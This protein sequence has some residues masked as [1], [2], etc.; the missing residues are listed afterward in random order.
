MSYDTVLLISHEMTY[1]GAPRSLLNIARV[2]ISK[3]RKINVWTLADGEFG[4]EF[5]KENISVEIIPDVI[6]KEE[7]EKYSLVILNTYFTAHL[8]KEIQK[9]TRAILYI[10]EAQNIPDLSRMCNLSPDDIKSANEAICVSDYA[11]DFIEGFCAPGRLTVINNFV[12]DKYRGRMN[13]IQNGVINFM[14]SGTYEKRKGYDIAIKAFLNMPEQLKKITRLHLVGQMPEWSQD[15]WEQ[16]RKEYDGRI[17][18]HGLISDEAERLKLYEEMNVFVVASRDE[19]CSLVALE[20]AMLGK[21]L[22]MSANTG[23]KYLDRSG[24]WVY[25][26]EDSEELCR[27]MCMLTSRKVLF[28]N[29]LMMRRAYR[30]TSTFKIFRKN[31]MRY[32]NGK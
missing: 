8:V 20:G 3:G 28:L 27:K 9:Y 19:S 26:T 11:K 14:V 21:A 17:I 29:G 22:L 23:A 18:E 30:K 16:L 25:P 7:I 24:K 15:Y 13:Y 6:T 5:E 32:I 1:T 10:R 2:L 4:K 31:F 12:P